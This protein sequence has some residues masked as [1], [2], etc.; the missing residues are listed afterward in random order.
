LDFEANPENAHILWK[1][2]V[3]IRLMGF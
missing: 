1:T 2:Q 3:L